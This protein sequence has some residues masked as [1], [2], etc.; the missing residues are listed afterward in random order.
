M[1]DTRTPEQTAADQALE[2]A[3]RAHQQ[4]YDVAAGVLMEWVVITTQHVDDG[5]H[6]ATSLGWSCPY[7]QPMHRTAGLVHY[8]EVRLNAM[9]AGNID[10]D[11]SNVE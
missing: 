2:D 1:C 7:A 10:L 3:I 8:A 5:H 6:Q 9:I 11:G 4:A